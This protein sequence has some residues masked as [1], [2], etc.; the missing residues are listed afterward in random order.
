[1]AEWWVEHGIGETRAALIEGD[2]ILEARVLPDGDLR[3]GTLIDARLVVRWP[4][5]NQGIVAWDGGE[6]IVA[7]LPAGVT[8]GALT[9]VEIVRPAIGETG[10]PKRARARPPRGE[11]SPDPAVPADAR[12]LRHTD[13]DVLEAAGWSELLEQ[14]ATGHVDFT[15]GS[16]DVALTSAMTLID[17]DGTL[18]PAALALAGARAGAEAIRR[19][20]LAGSIGMD[21]PDAGD[22]ATR[23]AVAA[24]VDAAMPLPFERTAVN[25][26]GFLQIV[27]PRRRR[28]LPELYAMERPLAE[29]RALLR[30][31]ERATGAGERT[32]VAAPAVIAALEERP[33]WLQTLAARIGAPVALRADPARA[34]SAGHVQARYP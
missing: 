29:A 28:S 31:A 16:L 22:K 2:R 25:G 30:Q 11:A 27:R 23:L 24:V 26:F 7:P 13:T 15:G 9:R 17:V 3:A 12:V 4:D 18:A 32:L 34:I 21:L 1:M 33:A 8:Q 6:A 5:R 14:A 20:D 19:L 10:K